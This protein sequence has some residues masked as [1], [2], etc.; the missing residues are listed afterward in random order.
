MRYPVEATQVIIDTNFYLNNVFCGGCSINKD[1]ELI[2]GLNCGQ[3][4]IEYCRDANDNIKN[5]PRY[6]IYIK[7]RVGNEETYVKF[8]SRKCERLT[9]AEFLNRESN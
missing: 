8:Q 1:G 3:E 2:P 5:G 9:E 7:V 4:C 6:D